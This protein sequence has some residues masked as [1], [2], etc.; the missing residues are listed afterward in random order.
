MRKMGARKYSL[1]NTGMFCTG[2]CRLTAARREGGR[3]G[4]KNITAW[5][6]KRIHHE[7]VEAAE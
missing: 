6:F 4:V 3:N 1:E 5:I 2:P 7:G